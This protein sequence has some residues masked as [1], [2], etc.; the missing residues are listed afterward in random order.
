M[1]Y[2][3]NLKIFL[4]A[5]VA[6]LLISGCS[7]FQRRSSVLDLDQARKLSFEGM[8]KSQNGD[9]EQA[10]E[11]FRQAVEVCPEDERARALLAEALWESGKTTEALLEQRQAV[12][13]SGGDPRQQVRLGE[14][15]LANGDADQ[16][17]KQAEYAIDQSRQMADAWNLKGDALETQNKLGE[18]LV[19]YQRSLSYDAQQ[20]QVLEKVAN[21]YEQLGRPQRALA[22]WYSVEELYPEDAIPAKVLYREAMAMQRLDRDHRAV[23]LLV[24]A[25]HRDPD[26]P[27]VIAALASLQWKLGDRVNS[28]LTAS[29][30]KQRWPHHPEIVRLNSAQGV[31]PILGGDRSPKVAPQKRTLYR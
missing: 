5:S 31:R 10:E 24:D 21:L 16:A 22:T 30:G 2:R 23:Q 19:C 9:W 12:E 15:L 6:V 17:M 4:V 29:Y 14:M 20:E 18:S 7:R 27:E 1:T 28:E 3:V 13:H 25:R 11:S 8:R 26:S